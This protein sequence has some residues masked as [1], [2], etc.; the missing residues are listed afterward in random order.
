MNTTSLLAKD[1]ENKARLATPGKQTQSN[2]NKA[3]LPRAQMNLKL[4]AKKSGH[5]PFSRLAKI[6]G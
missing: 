1:Y 2:P 5:T 6:A 4:L 3:N